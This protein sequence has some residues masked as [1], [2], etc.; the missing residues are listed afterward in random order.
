MCQPP[1]CRII[2]CVFFCLVLGLPNSK[3]KCWLLKSPQG[4]HFHSLSLGTKQSSLFQRHILNEVNFTVG[5]W[6]GHV[7]FR[8][9]SCLLLRNVQTV[10]K[11]RWLFK[12]AVV[13]LKEIHCQEKKCVF[14]SWNKV[15]QASWWDYSYFFQA[16]LKL[17]F[18][19]LVNK[20][21][22]LHIIYFLSWAFFGGGGK[23]GVNIY[24]YAI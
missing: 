3:S 17:M 5:T 22:C 1:D 11:M 4:I 9:L 15:L 12:F 8:T 13:K 21:R 18:G 23:D 6:H 19:H 14:F 16:E 24:R 10:K 7:L 20:S 2:S